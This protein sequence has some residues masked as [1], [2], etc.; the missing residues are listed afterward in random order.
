MLTVCTGGLSGSTEK[1]QYGPRDCCT[2]LQT[3]LKLSRGEKSGL[4]FLPC[5]RARSVIAPADFF[6]QTLYSTVFIFVRLCLGHRDLS[7]PNAQP[8]GHA[9]FAFITNRSLRIWC[10]KSADR[11]EAWCV[12]MLCELHNGLMSW[13]HL[14]ESSGVGQLSYNSNFNQFYILGKVKYWSL[15]RNLMVSF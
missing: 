11:Q 4:V 7:L 12:K 14:L 2:W 13:N 9:V 5:A 15:S 8:L 3:E 1:W 6:Q 10:K